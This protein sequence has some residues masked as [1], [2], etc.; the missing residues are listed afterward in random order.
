MQRQ[1]GSASLRAHKSPLLASG[2][3]QNATINKQTHQ[4]RETGHCARVIHALPSKAT[5]PTRRARSSTGLGGGW[6]YWRRRLSN[7]TNIVA[8]AHSTGFPSRPLLPVIYPNPHHGASFSLLL[9]RWSN[10]HV[11]SFWTFDYDDKL[12]AVFTVDSAL[13]LEKNRIYPLSRNSFV[14]WSHYLFNAKENRR[15]GVIVSQECVMTLSRAAFFDAMLCVVK[16]L[17]F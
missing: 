14:A 2:I 12:S 5:A 6:E 8:H 16:Y 3:S 10:S 7:P 15:L 1:N 17:T 11:K 9:R 13:I 4:E